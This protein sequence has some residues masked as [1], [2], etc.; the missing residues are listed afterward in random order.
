MAVRSFM[1]GV[2]ASLPIATGYI[3]VA[4]TYGLI[5]ASA[6]LST[7]ETVVSSA[8]IFA[9]AAQFLAVGLYTAGVP[10]PQLL[11]SV[12][13]LNLRHLLM[14]SVV[15]RRLP[16]TGVVAR[17]V[18]AFGIT[19]EVFGVITTEAAGEDPV[20]PWRLAGLEAGAYSAWVLGTAAGAGTGA[21]I[22]VDVRV[23]MG[24]A[25]YI[26]FTA[27]LAGQARR[28]PAGPILTA[29]GTAAATNTVLR[30]ATPLGA[31][32]AFPV[33]MIMGGIAGTVFFRRTP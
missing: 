25:L 15:A 6:G 16:V 11:L 2:T 3:P 31:G 9:G 17:G 1:K 13:L 8:L 22:P 18:L 23:A 26:L 5:A 21:I 28:G 30:L 33:A 27:L 19:D 20:N 4:V 32:V 10:L 29:A 7:G 24:L 14:S 12:W